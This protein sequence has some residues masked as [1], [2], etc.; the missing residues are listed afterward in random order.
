MFGIERA[1]PGS[2]DASSHLAHR[3]RS[4]AY[5]LATW[6]E[7]FD[8]VARGIIDQN[9]FAA[10]TRNDLTAKVRARLPQLCH[11]RREIVGFEWENPPA[12]LDVSRK[13]GR[14][15]GQS[16]IARIHAAARSRIAPSKSLR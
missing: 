13:A 2:R 11:Q 4:N 14:L 12:D 7:Q 16:D 5:S 9:L 3:S 1:R 10:R 6:L 15:I 8:R